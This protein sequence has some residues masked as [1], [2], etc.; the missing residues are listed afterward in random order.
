[1]EDLKILS[2]KIT[3]L[4]LVS[5]FFL[6]VFYSIWWK[7]KWLERRLKQQGIRGNP[8]KLLIGDMKDFMK[9]ITE[10]WSKPM[11][12]SHQIAPRVDPF[13]LNTAQKYG[14]VSLC[15]AGTTPRLNIMDPDIIKEVLANKQG[16]FGITP[17][18]LNPLILILTEG[19]TLL[20]GETWATHRRIMTP[21]FNSEK[22]KGMVSIFAESCVLLVE[23]WKKSI[24]LGGTCEIDVWPEFQ[25]L[26][27]DI[28]S[29]T[30]FGSNFDEGNQILKLQRELQGLVVEAMQSLYIPGLRF[31]PTR[32][33]RRRKSLDKNIT[34]M[35][36][37]LIERKET[38]MRTGQTNTDDLLGLLL[39]SNDENSLQSSPQNK[40]GNKMTIK[41]IIEECKQFYIAGQETTSSLLTWTMIILAMHPEWQEQAREEVLAL[42]GKQHPDAKTISQLKT[43]TMILH[44]VLRLYPPAIA[45][46]KHTYQE[47]KIG[48]LSLP[49]GVDL[50]LPLLLIHH[51][52]ELWGSDAEEFKPERFS[53]GLS[54]ASKNQLAFFPFGWGPKTCIGQNFALM[55]AKIALSIILQNFSFELSPS[56]THAPNTVM[57]LQPQ[58]GAP[59]ILKE[60]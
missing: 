1:M 26:T 36:R 45:L 38:L 34:S 50:T 52:P 40:N 13:T 47:T 59:I 12:L 55:E 28:I 43:V 22:L 56:Y 24:A 48:N 2:L 25:D 18:A 5:Y 30:A 46:Y 37:S 9:Q 11:S 31:I 35:L 33:N 8:Y 57:T 4:L 44:E 60:I 16:H 19:L 14:K 32:K 53:E 17:L 54:K 6:K 51:D 15:W 58:H 42:C 3:A 39:Q 7:P 23:K 21:A 49:A 20:E 10:A 27:G 41:E 29:R